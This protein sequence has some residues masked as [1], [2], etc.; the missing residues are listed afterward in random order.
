MGGVIISQD[1][2]SAV[3]LALD[4]EGLTGSHMDSLC[5][6]NVCDFDGVRYLT[7]PVWKADEA[8]LEELSVQSLDAVL[9]KGKSNTWDSHQVKELVSL[10]KNWFGIVKELV[11]VYY[12]KV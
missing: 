9:R 4:L 2:S 10:Q 8:Q 7:S 1:N 3:F 12:N 11:A 5:F 6:P